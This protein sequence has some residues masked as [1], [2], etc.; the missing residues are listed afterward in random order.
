MKYAGILND[1]EVTYRLEGVDST[2]AYKFS[3]ANN[4]LRWTQYIEA[5]LTMVCTS[6]I[7]NAFVSMSGVHAIKDIDIAGMADGEEIILMAG[8]S[9]SYFS[10][11]RKIV[12]ASNLHGLSMERFAALNNMGVCAYARSSDSTCYFV[13]GDDSMI[14]IPSLDMLILLCGMLE[15]VS[16]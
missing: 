4:K 10:Y 7:Q 6:F 14:R 3:G 8:L 12:K 5:N 1:E 15:L 13:S 9:G 2:F 16:L 11:S